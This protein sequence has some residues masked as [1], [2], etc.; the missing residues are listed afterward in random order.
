MSLD[1]VREIVMQGPPWHTRIF[2]QLEFHLRVPGGQTY[3]N[4][5]MQRMVMRWGRVTEVHTLEDTQLCTRL[6]AW[7]ASRGQAEALAAPITREAWPPMGRLLEGLE[8]A[9]VIP[10]QAGIHAVAGEGAGVPAHGSR[11]APG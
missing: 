7:Q 8:S 2:T 10:A 1:N 3:T 6:L 9:V 4:V 11:L 5:V